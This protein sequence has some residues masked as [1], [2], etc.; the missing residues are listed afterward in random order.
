MAATGAAF[1]LTWNQTDWDLSNIDMYHTLKESSEIYS[2]GSK[3]LGII[4]PPE[5]CI[6]AGFDYLF[7]K[8]L[9]QNDAAT[10]ICDGRKWR[11]KYFEELSEK[12]GKNVAKFWKSLYH[13]LWKPLQIKPFCTFSSLPLPFYML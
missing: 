11:A 4:G 8:L 6:V 5:P 1:R 9:V 3:A 13:C 2:Y 10:C 12:Y 7:S